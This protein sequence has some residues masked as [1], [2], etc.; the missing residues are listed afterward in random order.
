MISHY[1]I[2]EEIGRGGMGEVYRANDSQL[3]RNVA[4]KV[5]PELLARDRER[6]A[7]FQREAQ[8]L[9]SLNHPHIGAIYG[10][11][12]F[13]GNQALVL[14]LV[15]GETLADWMK[16]GA[17][18]QEKVLPIA[19][20][21]AEALEC[22]HDNGIIHRDLKPANVKITPDGRV[23]V[24]DFG[25]AKALEGER[26]ENQGA[27]L[28]QSPTITGAMTDVNV[29]LGTAAY[30]SPEQARGLAVDKR[31][32]IWSFGVL[33]FEMLTGRPKFAGETIS[34]TIAA[35]L[36]REIDWDVLP[37]ETPDRIHR[38]LRRCLERDP[39]GRL[40]DIGDARIALSKTL[41]ESPEDRVRTTAGAPGKPR[42]GHYAIFA[43][44]VILAASAAGFTTWFL[45]P[46]EP[47]PPLRKFELP[48]EDV[49]PN[50]STGTTFEI[51][52]DGSR[53]AYVSS[54]QL[55]VRDL[56]RVEAYAL[57]G[58]ED[59]MKPFWS[60]DG[61]WIGYGAA[62]KLWK[63]RVTGG[64]PVLLCEL[65]DGFSPAAGGAWGDN[66]RI[67][68][69]TG[70]AGLLEVSAQGGD[71]VPILEPE[72]E[73]EVDFHNVSRLPDDRGHLYVVHR[74]EGY[75]T[76]ELLVNGERRQIIRVEEQELDTPAYSPSGHIIYRRSPNNAGIWALPFSLSALEVTGE[77]FLAV[78]EG[79][80]PSVSMDGSM[81]Y[82][83]GFVAR[84]T[85]LLLTDRNGKQTGS[86]GSPANQ[87]PFPSF[88]PNGQ[89][90]AVALR[91]N[92]NR[93]IWIHDTIRG[94]ITRL[95]FDADNDLYP[96]WSPDGSHVYYM[97]GTGSSS[98]EVNSR[99]VDGTGTNHSLGKGGWH[100]I[101]PD[102]KYLL[103]STESTETSWDIW[104]VPI[105]SD[106]MAA[107]D[108]TI[109]LATP[110]VEYWPQLSPDGKYLAY[111]S[112]ESGRLETYI[113]QFPGGEGKWQVSVSGGHWPRWSEGGDEI[114]FAV[115]NDIMSVPVETSPALVLGAPEKLF[116]R[117]GS[118]YQLPF[119]WPDGF[120][121]SADGQTFVILENADENDGQ[122]VTGIT[123]VENW[124]AEFT[125]RE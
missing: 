29:I 13:E 99:A 58:T 48:L 24:L 90:I 64:A 49:D 97:N 86:I 81:I 32:D 85:Q 111:I 30:M 42:A 89:L 12:E 51:S 78:P 31:A 10:V 55:W 6:M 38:L 77:P 122:G 45:K 95:T 116:D 54:D 40:R 88:S 108:S 109:F 80:I 70:N 2:L 47:E 123:F 60:P 104:Y 4:I 20:Q 57:A 28:S 84:N 75:D 120:D 37:K 62:G 14:E 112:D 52:P 115:G 1:E 25:L 121:V 9:A 107:G 93:D 69:C 118:G 98:Y 35:V 18:S 66:G 19:L 15:E 68:Y 33:L 76:I 83:K 119:G 125:E 43:A 21:I 92:E 67:V 82:V 53:I 79:D 23:K 7:R 114:F 16:G 22:A 8:L 103:F 72:A 63:V 100:S 73:I 44:G 96:A 61:E 34:D 102:G 113:K 91:E 17:M 101:S 27:M 41:A 59:A 3:K 87:R 5:L 56:D 110:A 71:P 46:A 36:M 94:T 105:K 106:G 117:E 39:Q 74:K 26:V 11:E 50:L 65:E 124:Y